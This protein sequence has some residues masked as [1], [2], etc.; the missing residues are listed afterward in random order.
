MAGSSTDSALDLPAVE[1]SLNLWGQDPTGPLTARQIAGG[2]SNLTFFLTD[3]ANRRWVLRRPPLGHVMATAHDVAREARVLQAL[4]DA[5][6]VPSVIGT[7]HDRD[8]MAYY[9]MDEV[10]G[11]VIR[12]AA[13]AGTLDPSARTRC[14]HSLMK[15]LARLHRVEPEAVGLGSLGRGT[16]YLKRQISAWQRMGDQYRN[17]PFPEADEVRDRLLATAPRQ[18]HVSLVHGDYRLDNVLVAGDGSLNAILDWELCT[19]GDPS[20][21]LAVCL[22]YWTEATD[23]IHPFPDPP[24]IGRGFLTREELLAAYVAAGGRELPRREYYFAYA[25]WRLALVLEGVLGRFAAG[26]YGNPD[27]AEQNRLSRTVKLL[28]AHAEELLDDEAR[29]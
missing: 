20:V 22:Y 15:G 8:G 29:R 25:A 17:Q 1:A 19:R 28:V 7:G 5:V 12:T 3:A 4:A 13:D 21:D 2:R 11:Q 9:V 27:P 26:A 18:E 23:L 24:T 6:P 14:G 10:C 16:D